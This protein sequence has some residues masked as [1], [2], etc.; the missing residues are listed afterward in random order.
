MCMSMLVHGGHEDA[1]FFPFSWL[2]SC[3]M[4]K[5]RGVCFRTKSEGREP[6][7]K[8]ESLNIQSCSDELMFLHETPGS[9][10][11]YVEFLQCIPCRCMTQ[12]WF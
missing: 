8:L 7:P 10:G 2:C 5:K 3:R 6:T 12:G 11:Q 1:F 4:L 9:V